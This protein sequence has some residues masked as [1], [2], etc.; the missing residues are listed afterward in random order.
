[1]LHF[2]DEAVRAGLLSAYHFWQVPSHL[3]GNTLWPHIISW[4]FVFKKNIPSSS[5][6]WSAWC[7]QTFLS[8]YMYSCM[9]FHIDFFIM[10]IL[11][12]L[13]CWEWRAWKDLQHSI[14]CA[15]SSVYSLAS[16]RRIQLSSTTWYHNSQ[17]FFCWRKFLIFSNAKYFSKTGSVVDVS[18]FSVSLSYV[19]MLKLFSNN[20]SGSCQDVYTYTI[21]TR[22]VSMPGGY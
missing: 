5:T 15:A 1:M 3:S 21:L 10:K 14:Q 4:Q 7:S 22:I 12:Y 2:I 9:A 20:N 11:P 17:P 6:Y 13:S 8:C 16:G 19:F 18:R